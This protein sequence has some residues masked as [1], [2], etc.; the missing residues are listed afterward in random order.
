M[1]KA[2]MLVLAVLALLIS[3]AASA[4]NEIIKNFEK[5]TQEVVAISFQEGF[6]AGSLC[7]LASRAIDGGEC[8]PGKK[9]LEKAKRMILKYS[10][11]S[12]DPFV[13]LQ[14]QLLEVEG[15]YK[16]KCEK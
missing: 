8:N 1:K 13:M 2:F 6:T 10:E 3:R 15:A 12:H 4:E 7:E 9:A 5:T 14:K 11:F 16:E